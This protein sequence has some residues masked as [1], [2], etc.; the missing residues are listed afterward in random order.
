MCNDIKNEKRAETLALVPALTGMSL[1]KTRMHAEL[2]LT[3]VVTGYFFFI[4]LRSRH[5][6]KL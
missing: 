3:D 5:D 6:G 4:W 1:Q 2:Q